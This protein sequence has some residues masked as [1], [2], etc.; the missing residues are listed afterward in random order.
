MVLFQEEGG[1][2]LQEQ[3]WEFKESNKN[4][5]KENRHSIVDYTY[6]CVARMIAINLKD[7][8]LPW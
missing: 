5:L 1:R 8:C 3:K 4:F 7:V 6:A 2:N